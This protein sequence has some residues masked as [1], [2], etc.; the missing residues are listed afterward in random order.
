MGL[1]NHVLVGES[2]AIEQIHS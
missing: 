1:E 2:R